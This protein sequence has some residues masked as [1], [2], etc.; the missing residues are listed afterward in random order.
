MRKKR[1]LQTILEMYKT[2]SSDLV[3]SQRAAVYKAVPLFDVQGQTDDG[4]SQALNDYLQ[5]IRNHTIA[6][7]QANLFDP[8]LKRQGTADND[9]CLSYSTAINVIPVIGNAN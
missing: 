3:Q 4:V 9:S 1:L 2:V 7:V 6:V 5:T 8:V